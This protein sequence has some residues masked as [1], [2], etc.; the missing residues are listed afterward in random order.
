MLGK[1][2]TEFICNNL[3]WTI[4][5]IGGRMGTSVELDFWV[6]C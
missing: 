3:G 6:W 1:G 5:E 2:S 4:S